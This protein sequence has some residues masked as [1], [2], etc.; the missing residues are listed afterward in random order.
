MAHLKR[1]RFCVL[2]IMCVCHV[3]KKVCNFVNAHG[4]NLKVLLRMTLCLC[5]FAIQTIVTFYMAWTP[6]THRIFEC[7]VYIYIC[8]IILNLLWFTPESNI[9]WCIH[10]GIKCASTWDVWCQKATLYQLHMQAC[11]LEFLC[12]WRSCKRWRHSRKSWFIAAVEADWPSGEAVEAAEPSGAAVE[13]ASAVS[14]VHLG[15][16]MSGI[17]CVSANVAY[18]WSVITCHSAGK[19]SQWEK[20]CS[21]WNLGR[22]FP[23]G[24]A[25]LNGPVLEALQT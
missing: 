11:I 25:S 13:A 1:I 17:S 14:A 18:S 7:V 19:A 23:R 4:S 2:F 5:L 20:P 12:S 9:N 22:K 6:L 8:A 24:F 3:N 15:L 10:K 16:G 21:Q